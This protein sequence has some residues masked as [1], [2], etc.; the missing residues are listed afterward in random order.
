[1]LRNS[2]RLVGAGAVVLLAVSG[3]GLGSGDTSGQKSQTGAPTGKVTGQITFQTLQLKPD[4]DKYINGVVADFQT[5]NPGTKVNWVDIP[6]EGAQERLVTDATAG[7]LPD[8]VNLNPNFAQPLE[9]KDL[10]IDLSKAVPTAQATYVPGA[11]DSF[12]IPGK[13]GSYGFPW[14]LTSEVTMYNKDLF[15]KAGLD[16]ATPPATFEELWAD[17]SKLATAGNGKFYGLHP[18][19]ENKFITDL[20]KLGVPLLNEEGTKWTFNTPE[21]AAYVD[22][23]TAMYK[24]GVMPKDSLTQTHAEEIE[25]YQAGRVALFPSGP[26]F[27]KIIKENAP[28][29]AKATGVGPQITGPHGVANMSVMGLLVPKTGKNQ[30]TALAFAEFMTN[31]K[32]QVAFSKIVTVLPSVTDALKDPY[33]TDVS[34]GTTQSQARK[35]S[36]EQIPKAVNQ[37]PVQFDDRIKAVVIGKIQLAMQ[38]KLTSK[39]ALDQAVKEADLISGS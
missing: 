16:P 11:W 33:F 14:Y 1:M 17:A 30:A 6:F 39:D 4:F 27:L 5:Q 7:T 21:A 28:A 13:T 31:A 26:N 36:A 3:C 10:F 20:A 8:V 18:A 25:A 38:G 37:V 29:I 22:R 35:I 9:K 2:A 23:L 34:D 15:K 32:N 19:L 12:Q 24:A